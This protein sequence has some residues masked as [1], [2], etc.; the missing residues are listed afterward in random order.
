M[1]NCGKKKKTNKTGTTTTTT[2]KATATFELKPVVGKTMT[3][4]S[5]LEADAAN[6]R[7]GN[8][9]RVRPV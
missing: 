9:G 6:V 1:C 4:G 3:F 8:T 7:L 2:S 5:R